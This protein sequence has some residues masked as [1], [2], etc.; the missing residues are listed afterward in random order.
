L[1]TD[2]ELRAGKRRGL[3]I[4]KVSQETSPLNQHKP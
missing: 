2:Q 4:L 1:L 3:L